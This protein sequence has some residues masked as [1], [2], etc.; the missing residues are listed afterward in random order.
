MS[1]SKRATTDGAILKGNRVSVARYVA[2]ATLKTSRIISGSAAIPTAA[3]RIADSVADAIV[4][5]APTSR[6]RCFPKE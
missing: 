2:G 6:R 4:I 5:S 1:L 3:Q